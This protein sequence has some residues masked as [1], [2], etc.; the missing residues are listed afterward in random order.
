[1][2]VTFL[3]ELI[4]FPSFT[5]LEGSES[6]DI[7]VS[8]PCLSLAK[9]SIGCEACSQFILEKEVLSLVEL[10][11]FFAEPTSLLLAIELELS[12][13]LSYLT[14]RTDE[15]CLYKVNKD[16]LEG[17]N[18]NKYGKLKSLNMTISPKYA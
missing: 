4:T 15:T 12:S 3:L 14:E 5:K 16:E 17:K 1:M 10:F 18:T 6:H 7:P 9:R 2:K 11:I 13:E 8:A